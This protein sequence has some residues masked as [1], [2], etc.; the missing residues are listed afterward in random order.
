MFALVSVEHYFRNKFP[1]SDDKIWSLV[2][3]TVLWRHDWACRATTCRDLEAISQ[4]P[5]GRTARGL[6]PRD[7]C[8]SLE[9]WDDKVTKERVIE[10]ARKLDGFDQRLIITRNSNRYVI[11]GKC[12]E[13]RGVVQRDTATF[14]FCKVQF[15][16]SHGS[17]H[18]G[19]AVVPNNPIP[20]LDTRTHVYVC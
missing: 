17:V 2:L 18:T 8:G 9:V 13:G 3:A 11:V 14:Q 12:P 7:P 5:S 10:E 16:W 1:S 15:I 6:Q 19:R 20:L 4:T